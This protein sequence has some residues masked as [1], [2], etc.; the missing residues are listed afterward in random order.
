[1]GRTGTFI[2]LDIGLEQMKSENQIDFIQI[3]N[4]LREQR[5]HMVQTIVRN[6]ALYTY[7]YS[8]P[9]VFQS[10]FIFLHD[11]L[12]EQILCGNTLIPVAQFSEIIGNF[13]YT[14]CKTKKTIYET[15]YQVSS[16]FKSVLKY[17]QLL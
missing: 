2:A 11:T 6:D 4:Q 14:D 15:Q 9:I 5:M 7:V 3:V 8:V 12:L 13:D 10:Q 1:M 16:N 17:Q